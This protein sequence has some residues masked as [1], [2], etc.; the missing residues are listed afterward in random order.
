MIYLNKCEASKLEAAGDC[1]VKA[2]RLFL[3]AEAYAKGNC[4]SKCLSCCTTGGHF[5]LG[6][7]YL[8]QWRTGSQSKHPMLRKMEDIKITYL[9]NCAQHCHSAGDHNHMMALVR[10]IHCMDQIRSFLKSLNLLDELFSLEVESK[11]YLEAAAIARDKGQILL[12]AEMHEKAGDFEKSCNMIISYVIGKSLWSSGME[13]WPFKDFLGKGELLMK[14]KS[15]AKQGSLS[16]YEHVCLEV[17]I[18]SSRSPSTSDLLHYLSAS[19]KFQDVRLEIFSSRMI[20]DMHFQLDMSKFFQ[21]SKL[22]LDVK[23]IDEM[24]S[25]DSLC[26]HT[27]LY[28]WNLWKA[29]I[30]G[31]ISYIHSIDKYDK[32]GLSMYKEFVLAYFGIWQDKSDKYVLMD[33]KLS[34]VTLNKVPVLRNKNFF[35]MDTNLFQSSAEAILSEELLLVGLHVLDKL[36][37]LLTFSAWKGYPPMHRGMISICLYETVEHLKGTKFLNKEEHLRKAEDLISMSKRT[38]FNDV[39]P[40]EWQENIVEGI[41]DLREHTTAIEIFKLVIEDELKPKNG[42]LTHRQIMKVAVLLLVIGQSS[43]LFYGRIDSYLSHMQPWKSF[44]NAMEKYFIDSASGKFNLVSAFQETLNGTF[45]AHW[46]NKHD[47]LSPICFIFLLEGLLQ[48]ALCLDGINGTYVTSKSILCE[49]ILCPGFSGFLAAHSTYDDSQFNSTKTLSIISSIAERLLNWKQELNYWF[50]KSAIPLR[51]FN[52]IVLRLVNILIIVYLNTRQD[53]SRLVSLIQQGNIISELPPAFREM[54]SSAGSACIHDSQDSLLLLTDAMKIMGNPAV[55]ICPMSNCSDVANWNAITIES[56]KISSKDYVL[57]KLFPTIHKS[58]QSSH[59]QEAMSFS[60][61]SSNPNDIK[62]D[63]NSSN[64]VLSLTSALNESMGSNDIQQ[65]RHSSSCVPCLNALL[66]SNH[67]QHDGKCSSCVPSF[68]SS[69][70]EPL[71]SNDVQQDGNSSSYVPSLTPAWNEPQGADGVHRIDRRDS[72][73]K[74]NCFWSRLELFLSDIRK[75]GSIAE[76]HAHI[77]GELMV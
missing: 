2:K 60:N 55:V 67:I 34:W 3:A 56:E 10:A 71:G 52:S 77:A 19:S 51:H 64:C 74:Y 1:F 21:E 43:D 23:H 26:V 18:L 62:Q 8:E 75:Y 66:G 46:R 76:R 16:F 4:F 5:D 48:M 37:S 17:E 6:L 30:S 7:K 14:A 12:E 73:K 47:H 9:K 15:M 36:K 49:F 41:I 42:R 45:E 29:K 31:A 27:L 32:N 39:L 24:V 65:D 57:H 38:L 50:K 58:D 40:Y 59:V 13:G 68:T 61:E 54:L 25:Q 44:F 53:I 63:G 35:W 11:N 28:Y 22:V 70:D 20:L 72:C 69:F 33:P